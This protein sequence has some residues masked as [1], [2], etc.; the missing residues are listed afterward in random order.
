MRI[1]N[2][3]PAYGRR[4]RFIIVGATEIKKK[5]FFITL[6]DMFIAIH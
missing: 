6:L 1:D 4:Y 2:G 5:K 3:N